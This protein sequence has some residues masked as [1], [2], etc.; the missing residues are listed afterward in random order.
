VAINADIGWYYSG[1][2]SGGAPASSV[3]GAIS[4]NLITTSSNA[5]L[6]PNIL[7]AEAATGSTDFLCLYVKNNSATIT[8]TGVGI[9][10]ATETPSSDSTIYLAKGTSAK[11]IAEQAIASITTE[12]AGVIWQHPLFSYNN[13]TL[14]DLAPGDY[15]SIW[16]KRVIKPGTSGVVK[17]YFRLQLVSN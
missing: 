9:F 10:I 15:Q 1:A 7:S 17:D 16:L 5:N 2:G 13:V 6:F 14:P 8:Y 4:A 3:G 12:P 11:N